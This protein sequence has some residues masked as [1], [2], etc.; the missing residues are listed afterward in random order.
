MENFVDEEKTFSQYLSDVF[1]KVGIGVGITAVVSFLISKN[2]DMIMAKFATGFVTLLLS[3]LIAEFVIAN[4]FGL[5]LQKM[6]KGTAWFCYI[7]YSVLTGVSLS[8]T[9]Y[10]YTYSSVFIAFG[11]SC[12][13]FV[14]MAIIGHNSKVD[15]SKFSG[16]IVLALLCLIFVSF[17][18][19]FLFRNSF[20]QWIINY[21]GVIL[22]L[23]LIAYDM[24]KLRNFYEMSFM[25]DGISE[26]LALYGAFQ[27]YLDFINLFIR[28]LE[29]FGKKDD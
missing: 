12:L 14:M 29:L 7:L 21:I 11:V 1:S 5:R 22:F 3:S 18:N 16:I 19:V 8:T 4:F 9:L 28:L 20:F 25:D 2:M 13:M 27:L 24:Q 15:L 26:K 23:F 6:S 17:L 10:Y